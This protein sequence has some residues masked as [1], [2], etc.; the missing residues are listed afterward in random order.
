MESLSTEN[1]DSTFVN[2]AFSDLEG[3]FNFDEDSLQIGDDGIDDLFAF[4]ERG[5]CFGRCPIFKLYIYESGKATYEGINFVELMGPHET[6]FTSEEMDALSLAAFEFGLDSMKVE[7]DSKNVTDLPTTMIAVMVN[8]SFKKIKM[9]YQYPEN[10]K[11]FRNYFDEI[12]KNKEW[13]KVP[14]SRE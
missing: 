8:G 5:A 1:S 10:L 13:T 9:R 12:I 3:D 14:S 4:M 7:Y 6:V 11:L 2:D